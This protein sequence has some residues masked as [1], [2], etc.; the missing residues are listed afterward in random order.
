MPQKPD[1]PSTS[2]VFPRQGAPYAKVERYPR[3]QEELELSIG[4]KFLTSLKHFFGREDGPPRRGEEP[5]DLECESAS[6]GLIGIQI[7]EA[8]DH[9]LRHVTEMRSTYT[10]AVLSDASEIL[11]AFSGCRVSLCDVGDPPYLPPVQSRRGQECLQQIISGLE[12]ITLL[13]P[14]LPERSLRRYHDILVGEA[15]PR[16]LSVAV[17]RV[18]KAGDGVPFEL[19]WSGAGPSHQ[20]D[21]PR[22]IVSAAIRAKL[23]KNYSKPAGQFVLL[24]YSTDTLISESAPD[25]TEARELLSSIPHPFDEAWYFY[26]YAKIELGHVVQLWPSTE[27]A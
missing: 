3:T 22:G 12:S 4:A 17:E 7:V 20:T 26:P 9:N 1:R 24:V 6:G 18:I 8:I 2:I 27:P 15:P 11:S 5:S 13:V 10:E 19:R 16:S 14:V 25:I 23:H 21:T